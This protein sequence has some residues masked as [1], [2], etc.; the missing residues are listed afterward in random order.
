MAIKEILGVYYTVNPQAINKATTLDVFC[1][2]RRS[3]I[4][5]TREETNSPIAIVAVGAILVGLIKYNPS[6]K[7]GAQVRRGEYLG[8]FYYSKST[9]IALYP[10]SKVALNKDLVRNS[11]KHSCKTLMKVG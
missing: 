6:V 10:H 1:E 3:I 2:N 7:V 8:A 4:V 11:V 9:V 5:L